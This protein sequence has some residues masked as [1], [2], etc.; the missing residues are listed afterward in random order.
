[1]IDF[2][3]KIPND[4]PLV[5]LKVKPL[6]ER[7]EEGI[8][9][10]RWMS[11]PTC[12]F[13][14]LADPGKAEEGQPQPEQPTEIHMLTCRKRALMAIPLQQV[15]VRYDHNK[16]PIY[17][18]RPIYGDFVGQA[19]QA[20][21]RYPFRH[22]IKLPARDPKTKRIIPGKFI[23]PCRYYWKVSVEVHWYWSRGGKWVPWYEMERE[24]PKTERTAPTEAEAKWLK[25]F[26]RTP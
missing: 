19:L 15:F 11:L 7:V 9:Y 5:K 23:F 3:V 10:A 25:M 16:Q 8:T 17:E 24:R 21:V 6:S 2:E 4:D 18:K 14:G 22:V 26:M 20:Q 12:P 1:M 13:C